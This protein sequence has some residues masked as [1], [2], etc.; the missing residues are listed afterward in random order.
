MLTAAR[1]RGIVRITVP[2][3][4]PRDRALETKLKRVLQLEAVIVRSLPGLHVKEM[5]QT[6]GYFAAPVVSEWIDSAD[7]VAVAGGRTMRALAEH[8]KPSAAP[9]AITFVQAMGHIASSSGAYNAV[10][11]SR[12]LA[13]NWKGRLMTLNTPIFL[14]DP[15]T[16]RRL[17]ALD[18][19]R[20]VMGQLAKADLAL[21]GIGTT[22]DSVFA[23]Q[24]MLTKPDIEV[25]RAAGAIGEILGRFFDASGR[26]CVTP[27]QERVVSLDLNELRIIP[28]RVGVLAGSDRSSALL[29]AVRSGLLNC[30]VID[31]KG[32]TALLES[33]K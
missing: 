6:L 26:E 3:Y 2:E 22:D 13:T 27:F 33:A 8:A 9:R 25:L 30:L 28:K 31:Q 19:I 4:E 23:E 12:L 18:Q 5:R 29:A 1:E 20:Q 15:E 21:V 24:K 32:A 16:C 14:P 10:E 17:L 11:V 7:I